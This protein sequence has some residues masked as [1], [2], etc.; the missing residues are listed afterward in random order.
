MR[1]FISFWIVLIVG[2]GVFLQNHSSD[3]PFIHQNILYY[4]LVAQLDRASGYGPEG[5]GFKSLRAHHSSPPVIIQSHSILSDR[6]QLRGRAD[7]RGRFPRKLHFVFLSHL[8]NAAGQEKPSS[9]DICFLFL[10]FADNLRYFSRLHELINA[11]TD[12][13]V[14][15]LKT[16][17]K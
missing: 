12:L 17:A 2:R 15:A 11:R 3:N 9:S 13:P 8:E 16:L 5:L 14:T 10:P 4:A 7:D 1:L 6:P